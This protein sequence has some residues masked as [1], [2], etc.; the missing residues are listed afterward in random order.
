[1]TRSRPSDL[2]QVEIINAKRSSE[3]I[4]ELINNMIK[5]KWVNKKK[6]LQNQLLQ[7]IGNWNFLKYNKITK[8]FFDSYKSNSESIDIYRY[9]EFGKLHGFGEFIFD[10]GL[11]F[12]KNKIVNL[13]SM[14]SG[15]D[16][17]FMIGKNNQGFHLGTTSEVVSTNALRFPKGSQGIK[18][19]NK[20]FKIL[21]S[22]MNYDKFYF[23]DQKV[24]INF[25]WII[26]SSNDKNEILYLLSLLNAGVNRFIFEKLLRSAGEKNLL[27]GIKAVKDFFRVPKIIEE[28]KHIKNSIINLTKTLLDLE[29]ITL[30]NFIDFSKV[31]KQKFDKISVKN[32]K[33]II[34]KDEEKI[35]LSIR[36]YPSLVSKIIDREYNYNG[37][38]F[39]DKTINL[40]D[41]LTLPVI[42][43][44]RQKE[45]K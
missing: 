38:N 27:L 28:N 2:H 14:P 16:F 6:I 42:D 12:P 8:L 30:S 23:S 34:K 44:Q 26:I 5:D 25:N 1:M 40:S 33:L 35:E 45:I 24:M 7:N 4:S 19:Y 11:V 9:T 20:R 13:N 21:W 15:E 43:T 32:N 3:S 10:K 18:V 22:Y 39:E 31:L 37:L 41:L 17:F 36:Q 29:K